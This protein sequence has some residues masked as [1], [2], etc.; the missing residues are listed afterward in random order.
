MFRRL[1][2]FLIFASLY[3]FSYVFF[4]VPFEFYLAY[5]IFVLYMP[6]FFSKFGIPK[7]PALIFLPLFFSGI[8]YCLTG[9]NNFQQF[10][11]TFL[12]FFASCLFYHYVVQS[13]DFDLKE[14][15]RLYLV[16]AYVI[17][18]IG[19]VQLI[20]YTIGFKQG[21]NFTWVFNKWNPS[22]GGLGVRISSVLSEPA[23]FAASL[24]PAFFTAVYNL[25][26]RQT[27]FISKYQS[28]VIAL[29]YPLSFSSL[30]IL[31]I[32]F[33]IILMLVNLGTI[34]Y[35]LLFLP[36]LAVTIDYSYKNVPEFRDRWDGTIEIY[37]TDNI[38]DYDIHG[39]SFVLYNNSH[40]AWENFK[41]HPIFGTGLGGHPIAFDKYTLTQEEG[42]V[43]IDFNK[44]DANSMFLRL[45]SETGVYGLGI[46]IL[47]LFRSW[48]SKSNAIDNE[49]WVMSNGLTII[50]LV[51]LIRQGHYFLN[52]FPLFL[53]LYYYLSVQNKHAMAHKRAEIKAA[54][55][56]QF[57]PSTSE[58]QLSPEHI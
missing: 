28:V 2:I 38:Y 3:A 30:G 14:L 20:S 46:I 7:W 52:G 34:R 29:V 12:G 44:M 11:K 22:V 8:I 15:F 58:G 10:F 53:W 9:D 27:V 25:F 5:L 37:T 41:K 17:T 43:Q 56:A 47:L 1:S 49:T 21:Y 19:I 57:R 31:A 23:Y 18:I 48:I 55:I 45:M 24:S 6:F 33:T 39:S 4:K 51:Y 35:A 36:L 42:A 40:V 54:E 13:Y 16:S 32:F 26:Q 50:I